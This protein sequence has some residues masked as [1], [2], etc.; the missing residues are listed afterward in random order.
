MMLTSWFSVRAA[1]PPFA[2]HLVFELF[3]WPDDLTG[4]RAFVRVLYNDEALSLYGC[5]QSDGQ[6]TFAEF[7]MMLRESTSPDWYEACGANICFDKDAIASGGK[8]DKSKKAK[9]APISVVDD[10][11]GTIVMNE[12]MEGA[13]ADAADFLQR[14]DEYQNRA[15]ISHNKRK[16]SEVGESGATNNLDLRFS[17]WEAF[18]LAAGVVLGVSA[19][20]LKN[21]LLASYSNHQTRRPPAKRSASAKRNSTLEGAESGFSPSRSRRT[22][23]V[24]QT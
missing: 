19:V 9:A 16:L 6:C 20:S 10:K 5:V 17:G 11:T 14:L 8:K 7:E 18:I 21:I 15:D 12:R 4:D 22:V 3:T 13:D 23:A 2:A 1:I 24:K